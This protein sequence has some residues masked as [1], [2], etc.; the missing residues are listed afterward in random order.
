[1]FYGFLKNKRIG[2]EFQ[3]NVFPKAGKLKKKSEEKET[4]SNR[5]SLCGLSNIKI[6]NVEHF[7]HYLQ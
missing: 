4:E 6:Q 3:F 7:T 5:G 1:M 2:H